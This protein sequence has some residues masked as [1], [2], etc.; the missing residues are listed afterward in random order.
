MVLGRAQHVGLMTLGI[1]IVTPTLNA[2][3]FLPGCLASVRAQSFPRVE[4]IVVDGGST[5]T[6]IDLA[7]AAPGVVCVERPGMKQSAALNLGL[8]MASGEIV[9]WLNA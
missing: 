4:H 3:A 5:D 8:R 7:R 9:A 1:S 2:A 6:T